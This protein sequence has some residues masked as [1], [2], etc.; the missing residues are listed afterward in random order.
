MTNRQNQGGS[1]NGGRQSQDNGRQ[2]KGGMNPQ[3]Q[4]NNRQPQRDR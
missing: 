2:R 4:D 3:R 1:H